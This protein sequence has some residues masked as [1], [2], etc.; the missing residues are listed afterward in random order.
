MR[1]TRVTRSSASGII[2]TDLADH[3]GVFHLLKIDKAKNSNP[4]LRKR[5]FTENNVNVFK[6]L[7]DRTDFSNIFKLICPNEAFN[8]FIDKYKIAFN[9]TFPLRLIKV[10]M[11]YIKREVWFTP[12]LLASSRTRSKLFKKKLQ[13][14][15]SDNIDKF[16]KYNNLFNKIKR[17]A[18]IQ[19]Y[20]DTL[21]KKQI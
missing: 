17:S 20:N 10:H 21:D 14:P 6:T 2:I 3:F 11:E 18:K 5:L 15:T 4:V 16:N 9:D 12:S 19:H 1:P 13:Y 7:L 8:A